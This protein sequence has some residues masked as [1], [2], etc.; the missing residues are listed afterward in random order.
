MLRNNRAT[1]PQPSASIRIAH[2]QLPWL[3]T[4]LAVG[5]AGFFAGS[6]L[7]VQR[8]PPPVS[9]PPPELALRID[10]LERSQLAAASRVDAEL[11]QVRARYSDAL[12]AKDREIA[13]LGERISAL[14]PPEAPPQPL[15]AQLEPSSRD[16]RAEAQ[17]RAAE[18]AAKPLDVQRA[19]NN[20]A[21]SGRAEEP[22]E[23]PTAKQPAV[24]T[25]LRLAEVRA[26]KL[27]VRSGPGPKH[28]VVAQLRKGARVVTANEQRNGWVRLEVPNRGWVDAEF[29][30]AI[31]AE[32]RAKPPDD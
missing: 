15:V 17:P 1:E 6:R 16:A 11:E 10:A 3:L 30:A 8:V 21:A 23:P 13:A 24:P 19:R 25:G 22:A 28:A 4:T 5:A 12:A 32:P 27:R 14:A 20:S 9:A 31:G 29:L 18:P 26:P 7:E 2:L